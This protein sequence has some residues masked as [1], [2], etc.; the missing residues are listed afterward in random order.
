MDRG[1]PSE[2]AKPFVDLFEGVQV[3]G[4][5]RN[6]DHRRPFPVV[7][8]FHAAYLASNVGRLGTADINVDELVPRE[9]SGRYRVSERGANVA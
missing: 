3:V 7:P 1:R 6:L 2:P 9:I 8:A 5:E 4:A